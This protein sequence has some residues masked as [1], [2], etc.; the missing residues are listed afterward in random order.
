[1]GIDFYVDAEFAGLWGLRI[2]KILCA[3]KAELALFF[4]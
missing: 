4:V 3:S 1:M 2:P